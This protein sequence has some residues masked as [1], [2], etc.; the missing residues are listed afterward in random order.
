MTLMSQSSLNWKHLHVCGENQNRRYVIQ[1]EKETPPRMWRKP[2]G[3][4]QG[5]V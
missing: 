3:L 1:T 4:K 2:N 5:N